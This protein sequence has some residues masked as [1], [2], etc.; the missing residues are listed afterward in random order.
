M[1]RL[2]EIG[3]LFV[4]FV[5]FFGAIYLGA[6]IAAPVV[7][8]AIALLLLLA[9]ATVWIGVEEGLS[10]GETYVPAHLDDSGRIV[11]GY[12]VRK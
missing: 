1:A 2:L 7:Y 3:L 5:L 8:A 9:V 12:G 10:R 11:P 6:R 4:P